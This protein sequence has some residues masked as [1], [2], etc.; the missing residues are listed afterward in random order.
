MESRKSTTPIKSSGTGSLLSIL[1][2]RG[3]VLLKI[4]I[5]HSIKS[6]PY[7]LYLMI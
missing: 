4:Y 2:P 3:E 7:S 5:C 6:I 1:K